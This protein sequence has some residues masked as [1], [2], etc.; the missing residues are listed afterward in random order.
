[1]CLT[2]LKVTQTFFKIN[3]LLLCKRKGIYL[4]DPLLVTSDRD[5]RLTHIKQRATVFGS[6]R[7]VKRRAIL[8]LFLCKY[9]I[10]SYICTRNKK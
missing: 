1:L 9:K 5:G 7:G 10:Q 3:R 6:I 8:F 2:S 4:P